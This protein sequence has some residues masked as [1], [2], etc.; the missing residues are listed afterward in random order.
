MIRRVA[1]V[2]IATTLLLATPA[3]AVPGDISL[4]PSPT[5]SSAPEAL[6]SAADGTQFAVLTAVGRIASVSPAGV[7]T[8]LAVA[9]LAADSAPSDITLGPD[10]RMWVTEREAN[11]L[12]ALTITDLSYQRFPIPTAGALPA[13]VASGPA[14][15]IWFTE[16]GKD[17]IGKSTTAGVITEY[18]VPTGSAPQDIV[19]GPDGAMWFTLPGAN[20]MGRITPTGTVS[21]VTLPVAN[22]KP[23]GVT[24]GPDGA[25]WV[26]EQEG[27][28][29]ARVTATGGVT[30]F[31]I[32]TAGAK[33]T[34]I[35]AGADGNLWFSMPGVQRIGRMTPSGALTEF[36][37]AAG[38]LPAGLNS[39]TDGNVWVAQSGA[40]AVA[41]ILTG[42]V[43]VNSA[44]PVLTAA[45][46]TAVGAKVSTTNGTWQWAPTSYTTEWL[47]CT[48]GTANSCT[49][50]AGATA[51]EYTITTEDQGR[52]VR[53][54][55]AATNLNGKTA[56]PAISA[57]L[58][59]NA[60]AATLPQPVIG[61]TSAVMGN[62]I[63]AT[64]NAPRTKKR[65]LIGVYR[66][67]FSVPT[68]RGKVVILLQDATGITVRTI[69][70][71]KSVNVKG[72][73]QKTWRMPRN[74]QSGT[75][76]VKAI[77]TPIASQ[78]ATNSVTTLSKSIFV[79]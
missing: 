62:G 43:P 70:P 29:V 18:P 40:N 45:A 30:R 17:R 44:V 32:T 28:A 64:L 6:A 55:I 13:A 65:G 20:A 22:A 27:N 16:P 69:A 74:L 3:M 58:L 68:V 41:R 53:A 12:G 19:A 51:A 25:L 21:T 77:Y 63:T 76:V 7:V 46:G 73:A 15:T 9:G 34:S 39:A 67:R 8:T 49:V 35:T 56:T 5:A 11:A 33:P 47:R 23:W 59:V 71:N 37:L 52:N 50:I 48:D 72:I 1:A 61:G 2:S 4:F 75:Y 60:A 24:V 31:P 57:P 78:A 42:V 38:A 66:M 10:G 26:T 14:N 54:R 36:S 79:R